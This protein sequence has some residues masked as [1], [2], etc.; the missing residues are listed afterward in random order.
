MQE[1]IGKADIETL[2]PDQLKG[3][4]C[5]PPLL[6]GED[7]KL[8]WGLLAA[9]VNEHKPQSA[10]EWIAVHDL[11]TKLWE[12]RSLRRASAALV[13]SGRLKAVEYFLSQI[14]TGEPSEKSVYQPEELAAM[15]AR[16]RQRARDYFGTERKERDLV[17]SQLAQYGITA[18]EIHAKATELNSEPLRMF[19]AMIARRERERRKQRNEDERVRRRR[20]AEQRSGQE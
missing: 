16:E 12:E 4:F 1:H 7:P 8:Y 18:A 20:E 5:E 10:T 3:L 19:E 14:G 13:H 9:L 11:M 15:R 6:E 2:I 17:R